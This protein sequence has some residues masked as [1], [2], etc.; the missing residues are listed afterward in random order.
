MS[1]FNKVVSWANAPV[2]LNNGSLAE[3]GST[4]LNSTRNSWVNVLLLT[5]LSQAQNLKMR[6][7]LEPNFR[8]TLVPKSVKFCQLSYENLF[9]FQNEYLPGFKVT[10]PAKSLLGLVELLGLS[11]ST[12]L[13]KD[14]E[15]V[16]LGSTQLNKLKDLMRR[17]SG[18][19]RQCTR[20]SQP[21]PQFLIKQK[22]FL[23]Y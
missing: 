3:V 7:T 23:L 10:F 19:S 14:S 20:F 17:E 16:W 15:E 5:L 11:C 12:Q 2:Q 22:H 13:N 8:P 21:F 9:E 18:S 6:P 4:Q 1:R